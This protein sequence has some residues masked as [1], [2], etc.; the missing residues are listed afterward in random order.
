MR[1]LALALG[2][3]LAA[4]AWATVSDAVMF[5]K[6]SDG[7]TAGTVDGQTF[8]TTTK[9]S[10][11]V[12]SACFVL[13]KASL[14]PGG[15]TDVTDTMDLLTCATRPC[16][17]F[18]PSGHPTAAQS[19]DIFRIE[20]VSSTSRAQLV[21][22][23]A[24][25]SADRVS[26]RGLRVTAVVAPK[27]LT[28][29]FGTQ[30]GDL[31]VLGTSA[32]SSAYLATAAMSGFF[33]T[34]AT[35]LTRATSCLAGTTS[36]D[37]ADSCAKL[38]LAV[39]GT[40][41][42]GAG[43]TAI[44]TVSVPCNNSFPTVNPCGTNGVWSTSGSF[45][46]INDNKTISCPSPC[47]TAHTGTAVVEFAGLHVFQLT[48]SAHSGMS[49]VTLEEGAAEEIAITFADELGANRWVASALAEL[50]RAKPTGPTDGTTR[51][52]NNNSTIPL[53][54][55]L[56]CGFATLATG[57]ITL[58]SI[59]DPAEAALTGAALTLN[60]A[61]RVAFIP[62]PILELRDLNVVSLTYDV[63]VG[64]GPSG[65]PRVPDIVFSDC[66]DGSLRLEF[67]VQDRR[68]GEIGFLTVFLGNNAGDGFQSGCDGF[69]SIGLDIVN[70]PDARVD[71]S[72][73]PGNLAEPC[74]IT[75]RD[76]Q[77]GVTGQLRIRKM[78]LIVDQGSVPGLNNQK[79]TFL[80]GNVNGIQAASA[81]ETV[82][83]FQ[84]TFDLPTTGVSMVVTKISGEDQG[85]KKVI[86]N[87]EIT[88]GEYRTQVN[89]NELSPD[90]GGTTYSVDLCLSGAASE[91]LPA[92]TPIG[93]CI[94]TQAIMTLL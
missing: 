7:T 92:N 8:V 11:A 5:V 52:V 80:N 37:V 43:T 68:T 64:T 49:N 56:E 30:V 90:T 32:T 76:A 69:E 21:K 40:E 15:T 60:D 71:P 85:V 34:T 17:L 13:R 84:R 36:I 3:M 18:F 83:D 14:A 24:G 67:Q 23:D 25:T 16:R 70:N 73:L 2:L 55:Q 26:V 28:L 53:S 20:D 4:L 31:R 42:N 19:G 75:F 27:N 46:G 41:V 66:S 22:F 72:R 82:T 59:V 65:D 47:T 62:Q 54:F 87:P 45:T 86:L 51:N 61:G 91:G 33:R 29:T 1:K 48:A 44:A 57:G 35:G 89:V 63:I 58:L 93:I 78:S 79:V 12:P 88:G 6:Y 38:T 77:Q 50:C 10:T 74:C 81:L 9:C 94:P 39:N